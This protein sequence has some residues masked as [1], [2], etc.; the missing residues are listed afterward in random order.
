METKR[1]RK[2]ICAVKATENRKT[3][4]QEVKFSL[5]L[6]ELWIYGHRSNPMNPLIGSYGLQIERSPKTLCLKRYKF[7]QNLTVYL[8]R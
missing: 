6:K 8:N 1:N 7:L 5:I 3:K 2:G 4:V